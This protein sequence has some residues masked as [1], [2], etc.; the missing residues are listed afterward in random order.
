MSRS[1]APEASEQP[2]P[3]H[4]QEALDTTVGKARVTWLSS[5][6]P[7]PRLRISRSKVSTVPAM[8]V[9]AVLCRVRVVTRSTWRVSMTVTVSVVVDG[10]AGLLVT[11]RETGN[12]PTSV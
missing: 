2:V 5:A 11:V 8:A 7:G 6:S 12:S 1:P 4:D 9:S 3:L 10:Q